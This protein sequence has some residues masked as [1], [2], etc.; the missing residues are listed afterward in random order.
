MYPWQFVHTLIVQPRPMQA[1]P[2]L[3]SSFRRGD[4][5]TDNQTFFLHI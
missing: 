2:G 1:S 3:T 4:E 5:A